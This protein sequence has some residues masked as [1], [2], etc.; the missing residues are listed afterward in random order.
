MGYIGA[1][2][3]RFNTADDLTV[4][5]DAEFNGNLT[6]KGTTTTIDSALVQTI[7]LGDNDKIRLGDSDD[8]QIYHNGTDS[9]ID[10]SGTG[11]LFIRSNR[12]FID[13]YTGERIITA[14]A[15]GGVG[16]YFDN[17]SKLATT[18][19][20]VDVTGGLS[21]AGAVSTIARDGAI[22]DYS[23]SISR[24]IAGR[25]GGNYGQ[26]EAYVAGASGVT[27]RY[28][29]DYDSTTRWYA[30]NGTTEHMRISSSGN[31][32]IGGTDASFGKLSVRNGYL[33]VNEDNANTK[34][35]YIRSDFGGDPTI[36]VAT[37]HALKFATS[38]QE[39]MRIDSSGNVG[40]GT[41]SPTNGKLEVT[42]SS[43]TVPAGYFRNTSGSGDSPSLIVQGGANNAAPNFS[44]LD[45]NG[46]TDFVVQGS[47]N[48]GIGT[49][50]PNSG[51]LHVSHTTGTIGYFESTQA[52][53]NVSNVVLNATQTNSSA[54][55]TFQINHGTTA[56]AQLRLNG[57]SSFAIHNKAGLAESMRLDSSGRMR[58][59]TGAY[60]PNVSVPGVRIS[61]NVNDSYWLSFVN[62]TSAYNQ[63]AFGNSNGFCGFI[64]TSGTSTSYV[65]SSDYRLKENVTADWDATTRLKQLNPV[66]FNFIADADTTVDGFLAHE[67]QDIVPEAITGTKDAMRD[68]EYTVSAATGDIYTPAVEATF[69]D[70]GVELTAAVDEVIH[71]ADVE[72]PEE[73]AEGQQWRE[74][75]AAVMGT[76][77]VPDY[78]GIDQSKLVPLLVK[79]IQELEARIAALET[80]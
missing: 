79:T 21:T 9:F 47:G 48:V 77:S 34:Q 32:A 70:D 37:S 16:L 72:R 15:D 22:V 12:L 40:I 39:R 10:D 68:E 41:S 31:V 27:K 57:D 5:G 30:A 46:N 3:T 33:Y 74:T 19:T 7:D 6:V 53:A 52:A 24:F 66:R 36:Q 61:G 44:V 75:T 25:A 13:K 62:V 35:I 69:D 80:A 14:T 63:L 71:S 76:R 8:L 60:D 43:S 56:Q 28:Q 73:L 64:Q 4:T 17:S 65:T 20:G 59:N 54:N 2:P 51:K 23:G 38:N 78:Q 42:H 18:N 11:D 29:I 55:A 45:Y 1:G 49:T 67:V 26:W 58:I 50:N